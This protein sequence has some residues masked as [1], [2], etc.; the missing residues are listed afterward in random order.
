L[1]YDLA[2]SVYE[3]Y[4]RPALVRRREMSEMIQNMYAVFVFFSTIFIR[5][6]FYMTDRTLS[7]TPHDP[8]TLFD[9]VIDS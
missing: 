8:G 6:R 4:S 3:L 7:H 9:H 5:E 1:A 2:I